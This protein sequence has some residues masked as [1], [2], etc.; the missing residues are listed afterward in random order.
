M[1]E[2]PSEDGGTSVDGDATPPLKV[3]ISYRRADT[4]WVAWAL[5]FKLAD[6]FG[7]ENVFLDTDTLRGGARWREETASGVRNAGVFIALI[8][9]RWK[10]ELDDRLRRGDDDVVQE[11]ID[12]ALRSAAEVRIIPVVVDDARL[13]D[14]AQLP[15][16]LSEFPGRQFERLRQEQGGEDIERLLERLSRDGGD[17]GR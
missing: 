14:S 17:K 5:Y 8:G 12:W 4:G 3:F 6:R 11:E 7:A 15:P 9:P 2:P 16:A 13:P 10:T 1:T